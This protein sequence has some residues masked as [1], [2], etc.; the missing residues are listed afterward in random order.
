MSSLNRSPFNPCATWCTTAALCS[1]HPLRLLFR[2]CAADA[3]CPVM[4]STSTSGSSRLAARRIRQTIGA[5]RECF[6]TVA[7]RVR[8]RG[9]SR[10]PHAACSASARTLYT[11]YALS[12]SW[13]HT[14]RPGQGI[15]S[16]EQQEKQHGPFSIRSPAPDWRSRG[17][18]S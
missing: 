8:P 14:A 18:R 6:L 3:A 16:K 5:M 7:R 10:S 9:A 15:F 13:T 4:P 17:S 12:A 1:A 2:P 11:W